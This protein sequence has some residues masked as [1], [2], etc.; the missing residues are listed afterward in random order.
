[1]SVSE[2]IETL[3]GTADALP[4]NVKEK[5]C[6]ALLPTCERVKY[7]Y[8]NPLEATVKVIF[9]VSGLPTDQIL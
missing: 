5:D 3:N 7:I 9:A 1:M 6:A 8:E 2:L 4:S